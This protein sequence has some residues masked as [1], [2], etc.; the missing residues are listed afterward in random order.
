[1]TARPEVS[2]AEPALPAQACSRAPRPPHPSRRMS[3]TRRGHVP[4][5]NDQDTQVEQTKARRALQ[6]YQARP[7]QRHEHPPKGPSLALHKKFGLCTANGAPTVNPS[8]GSQSAVP[9]KSAPCRVVVLGPY[10]PSPS[11][12]HPLRVTLA[13]LAGHA[14]KERARRASCKSPPGPSCAPLESAK[15]TFLLAESDVT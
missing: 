15:P 4:P 9:R 6:T 5:A 7:A 13:A 11:L 1:M 3:R 2:P 10:P 14:G 8:M 12:P